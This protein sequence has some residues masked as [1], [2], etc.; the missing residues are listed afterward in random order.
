MGEI[1]SGQIIIVWII[2]L[3]LYLFD[4]HSK[5]KNGNVSSSGT[6]SSSG[7]VSMHLVL[8]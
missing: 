5:G 4:S 7:I 8:V 6:V 3:I 2:I 1:I